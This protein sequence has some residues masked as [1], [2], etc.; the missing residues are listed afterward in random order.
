MRVER[1]WER[2]VKARLW[3]RATD[4]VSPN[5]PSIAD[6]GP[7]GKERVQRHSSGPDSPR[8][9]SA[10]AGDPKSA[11]SLLPPDEF[12]PYVVPFLGGHGALAGG[13]APAHTTRWRQLQPAASVSAFSS[14]SSACVHPYVYALPP[15]YERAVQRKLSMTGELRSKFKQAGLTKEKER[16]LNDVIQAYFKDWLSGSGLM[17]QI[18][19]LSALEREEQGL[20][21][22]ATSVS[23]PPGTAPW[24]ESLPPSLPLRRSASG[25]APSLFSGSAAAG[26]SLS[27]A[28][29]ASSAA[30]AAVADALGADPAGGMHD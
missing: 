15:D 1:G 20:R 21:A 19:D 25:V 14:S 12:L 26:A 22:L 24:A 8:T 5:S 7:A 11:F 10:S 16:E 17:R 2:P 4:G 23:L 6:A 13:P 29:A 18:F 9:T 27:A 3:H 30:A 28:A